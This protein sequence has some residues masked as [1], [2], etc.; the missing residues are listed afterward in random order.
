MRYF[1]PDWDD[2]VDPLFDFLG[3]CHPYPGGKSA[4]EHEHYPH[5]ML[6]RHPCDGL[7]VSKVVAEKTARKKARVNKLGIHGALRLARDFPVL[8]DSGAFGYLKEEVP[9]YTTEEML[10]YYT[11]LGFDYGVSLD[12]IIVPSVK[13]Q[14]RKRYQLTLA[15]ARDFLTLWKK[16]RPPWTP[17]GAI[18]GWDRDSHVRAAGELARMG[19]DY[20]AVGGIARMPTP[21]VLDLA[22]AVQD[23]VGRGVR[24]HLFGLARL[25]GVRAM[26]AIGIHSVDSA[27]WLRQAWLGA[28]RNY[29]LPDGSSYAALRIPAAGRA[30]Q[31]RRTG[32]CPEQ[33]VTLERRALESVRRFAAS[34]TGDVA[35]TVQAVLDYERLWNNG[36]VRPGLEALYTRTLEE[37]P[38]QRC[39]CRVCVGAGVEVVIF[40]GSDR[41]R[42]R[43]F[44]NLGVFHDL[45]SRILNGEDV[46]IPS[47]DIEPCAAGSVQGM[48][49][50]S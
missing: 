38:W 31:R 36:D 21:Q 29:L 12:H 27:S 11:R 8:G 43:G 22:R 37:R 34:A 7:L 1:L 40:R 18:Q 16:E 17:I 25:A 23:E 9:P 41:N 35:G 4:W 3:D 49:F 2:H 20:I 10:D 24:V 48:L 28:E 33:A 6:G 44:H 45:F 26:Q 30:R 13:E 47:V 5:Q 39:Q 32:G 14:A 50:A 19:Y 46:G 42:R 15:N